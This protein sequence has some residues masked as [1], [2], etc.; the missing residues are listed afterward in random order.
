MKGMKQQ[1]FGAQHRLPFSK[2]FS[3]ESSIYKEENDD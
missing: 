2:I 1:G 3:A